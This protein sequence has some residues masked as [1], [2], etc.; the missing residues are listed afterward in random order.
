MGGM[1]M[2]GSGMGMGTNMGMGM[3]NGSNF[4]T[5]SMGNMSMGGSGAYSGSV[6]YV[7][8]SDPHWNGT[9]FNASGT[10]DGRN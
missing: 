3:G 6:P 4:S 8:A 5:G 7:N 10:W 2:S 1:G 9:F